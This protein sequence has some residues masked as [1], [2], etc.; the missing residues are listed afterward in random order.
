[1]NYK[2]QQ[3]YEAN[4]NVYSTRQVL[5][6]VRH[7]KNTILTATGVVQTTRVGVHELFRRAQSWK[8]RWE[9]MPTLSASV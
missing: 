4:G 8:L 5:K 6:D 1:M 2:L 9:P 7:E 3:E